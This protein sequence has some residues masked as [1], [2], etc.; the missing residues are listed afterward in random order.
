MFITVSDNNNN[1]NISSL[2][3]WRDLGHQAHSYIQPQYY[4]DIKRLRYHF[5]YIVSEVS[6]HAHHSHTKLVIQNK[7]IVLIM[8]LNVIMSINNVTIKFK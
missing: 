6:F 8:S 5:E 7:E 4:R 3:K 2:F 1:N